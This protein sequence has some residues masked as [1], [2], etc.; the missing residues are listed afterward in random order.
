[1]LFGEM[2]TAA[3]RVL[4]AL[5]RQERIAIYGDYDVDGITASTQ[6]VLFLREL[7]CEPI[8]HIPH[9][10]RDGYGLKPAA[11]REL[12][13]R[14][15]RLV[16]TAD[17]GAAA[18]AEIAEAGRLGLELIVCDHHQNPAVRPP[19]MVRLSRRQRNLTQIATNRNSSSADGTPIVHQAR[20][21]N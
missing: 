7:G 1:M 14:G 11:L 15:A 19:A 16:I 18:H 6:L 20:N 3:R 8:L 4:E 21:E 10:M 17:C 13:E 12:G 5:R 2:K 9:R